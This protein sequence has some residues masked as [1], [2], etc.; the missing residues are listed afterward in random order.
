MILPS[1]TYMPGWPERLVDNDGVRYVRLRD[2]N[3]T[4]E[5]SGETCLY[6]VL[7][8]AGFL[9]RAHQW[10]PLLGATLIDMR[11]AGGVWMSAKELH[12]SGQTPIV[13][14]PEPVEWPV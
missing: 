10:V 13:I 11:L 7:D 2:G 1:T 6:G 5:F 9:D 12:W 14:P 4:S 8:E 3:P